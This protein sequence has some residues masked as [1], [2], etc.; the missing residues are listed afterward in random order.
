MPLNSHF[1]SRF[2]TTP[3]EHGDR[4]LWYYDFEKGRLRSGSSRSLFARIGVN[5]PEVESRLNRLIETPIA[6]A[7]AELWADRRAVSQDLEWPLFRALALLFLLQPFR[8]ADSSDASQTLEEFISRPDD[9]IDGLAHAITLRWQLMRITVS[10]RSPL[11]YPS[12]GY[13]P[14]LAEPLGGI[15]PFGLAIPLSPIH[16]FVGVPIDMRPEQTEIWSANDAGFVSNYSVGHRSQF[17][18]V[19]PNLVRTVPEAE[20]VKAI[21]EAR[22]GVVSSIQLCGALAEV[23]RRMDAVA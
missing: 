18:V 15:C 22:A 13:F 1:V 10:N 8:S 17:V 2:L 9:E 12:D 19:H 11:A 23:L 16:A 4:M 20:V 6:A 3:W 7:R 5:T 21:R 14:L